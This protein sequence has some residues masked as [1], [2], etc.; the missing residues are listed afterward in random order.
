MADL[1]ASAHGSL[2]ARGLQKNISRNF[3]DAP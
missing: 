1:L 2:E 3:I